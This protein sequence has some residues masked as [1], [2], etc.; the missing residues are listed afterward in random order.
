MSLA[1]K[2]QGLS[3]G[4][5][6]EKSGPVSPQKEEKKGP[7]SF[8][9]RGPV[10]TEDI[11]RGI[12]SSKNE[13]Y[14]KYHIAGKE[15]EEFAKEIGKHGNFL[16]N[17]EAFKLKGDLEKTWR[18]TPGTSPDKRKIEGKLRYLKDKYGI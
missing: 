2:K 1:D 14:S 3:Q 4:A 15:A 9:Q 13:L 8:A 6:K 17:Q 5:P 16:N 10:K 7:P 18:T 12:I 11:K